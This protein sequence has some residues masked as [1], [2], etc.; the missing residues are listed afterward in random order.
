MYNTDESDNCTISLVNE[1]ALSYE[2]E[3]EYD[4]FKCHAEFSCS[5][6]QIPEYRIQRLNTVPSGSCYYQSLGING[7]KYCTGK[8]P[9]KLLTIP[10]TGILSSY[11]LILI[12]HYAMQ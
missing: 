8:L 2:T 1:T 9:D 10:M 5:V 11:G 7:N 3:N 4:E 6:G 12:L